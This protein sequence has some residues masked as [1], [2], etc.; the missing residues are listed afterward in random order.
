MLLL[1][2]LLLL[3]VLGVDIFTYIPP[4]VGMLCRR[5]AR[6]AA[7]LMVARVRPGVCRDVI[8]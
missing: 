7:G 8:A 2:L 4:N 6:F 1:L 5:D 3:C